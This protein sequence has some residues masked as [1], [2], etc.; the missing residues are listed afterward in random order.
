M[1]Y[2]HELD[3]PPH[4]R[5]FD[6]WDRDIQE[7][8]YAHYTW[9][10][11]H[12]P[13]LKA[14]TPAGDAWYLTRYHDVQWVL[15]SPKLFSSELVDRKVLPQFIFMDDPDHSR[16]R[17]V[18]AP[19][20]TPKAVARNEEKVRELAQK[21]LQALIEA[22]G[23]EVIEE[24]ALPLT[25][26]T[27][28]NILGLDLSDWKQFRDWTDDWVSYSGRM[29]G[30]GPGSPTDQSGT[31]AFVDYVAKAME[32]TPAEGDSILTS[33]VRTRREGRMSEDEAKYFPLVLFSA[34]HETTTIL[35]AN[36][37]IR[38]AEMPR[39]LSR[40]RENPA[41]IPK[42]VEELA[43]LHPPIHR[44]RRVTS[45]EVEISGQKIPARSHL[46]LLIVAANRDPLKFPNPEN[47]DLDRETAGHLGFGFGLHSCLGSWLARME[48]RVA[49][50]VIVQK[51]SRVEL[52][53]DAARAIL[54][55]LG[56]SFA[57]T[58][59]KSVTLR[60]TPAE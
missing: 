43:R 57:I 21:Y 29:T 15:R 31:R 3:W 16:L 32:S 52:Y 9:M 39:L 23:G 19:A 48:A 24:F 18:V 56:G 17:A 28:A 10:R 35:I 2:S 45:Q 53:P 38:L 55:Y 6:P 51:I 58:G 33:L 14:R 12:A 34:G 59:P 42:F 26:G 4:L 60:L 41:D 44:L 25:M 1:Q 37:L 47:F 50:E 5:P 20:F 8:P 49:F 22:G 30:N 13:L 54:P 36:G 7:D 40:L 46:R 27:I 11:D